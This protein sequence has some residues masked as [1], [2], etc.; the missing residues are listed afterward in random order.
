MK[1][2]IRELYSTVKPLKRKMNMNNFIN[3]VILGFISG[4]IL[5][6][7]LCIYALLMP[8]TFLLMKVVTLYVFCFISSAIIAFFIRPKIK[9]VFLK[10][11]SFGLEERM[12]TAY[13]LIEREDAVTK[14]QR[15]NA[16]ATAKE[17]NL[18]K[19]Y[20]FSIKWKALI[21]S[22]VFL[23]MAVFI[24]FTPSFSKIEAQK[25]EE[26][27]NKINSEIKK[28]EKEHKKVEET[29]K[30]SEAKKEEINKKMNELLKELKGANTEN[31][32]LKALAKA[33]NELKKID[34][35]KA[36]EELEKMADKFLKNPQ[37]KE[38]GSAIKDKDVNELENKMDELKEEIKRMNEK[39]RKEFA[40]ELKKYS[41]EI[42]NNENLSEKLE[43]LSKSVK[44][45]D[46]EE[47]ENQVT[48]MSDTVQKMM[49]GE[50]PNQLAQSNQ[51]K[52]KE[53][54]ELIDAVEQS[55]QNMGGAPENIQRLAGLEEMEGQSQTGKEG[56]S[57]QGT[58]TNTIPIETQGGGE[59]GAGSGDT[60]VEQGNAGSQSGQSKGRQPGEK[61]IEEY[62]SIYIP[63][64]LGGDS[65]AQQVKG[66]VGEDGQSQWKEVS[67]LPTEVGEKIPYNE[68]F[69]EYESE[70]LTSLQDDTIPP[71][72]KDIIKDYFSSLE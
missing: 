72:M 17:R 20:S 37:T 30:I 8:V 6:V 43:S 16:Y 38:I 29:S 40:E 64:R 34:N 3:V 60:N 24:Y 35:E 58:D 2:G 22:C 59:Q 18:S 53:I 56:M 10:A 32:A 51:Q 28:I 12:I 36:L 27:F 50:M 61:K 55:R 66:V 49:K 11:D 71:V 31:E 42:S 33:K 67:G 13:E 48:A 54:G 14:I 4:G 63:K 9:D 39:E 5:A 65:E 45:G 62:E 26:V 52:N 57:Q 19:E 21:S 1:I 70:A 7:G 41:E 46:V 23:V 69:R 15:N 44:S 25:Q 68:V 47:L